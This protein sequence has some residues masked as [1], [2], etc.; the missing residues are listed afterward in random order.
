MEKKMAKK[1]K[2]NQNQ[3][4][5][6]MKIEETEGLTVGEVIDKSE[7]IKQDNANNENTLDKYI[8]QHRSQIE[9]AKSQGL[10]NF[11]KAEREK[12]A[13][14]PEE[15]KAAEKVEEK[16]PEK[17]EPEALDKVEVAE[18]KSGK[19]AAKIVGVAATEAVALDAVEVAADKKETEP[20]VKA[21]EPKAELEPKA[22]EPEPEKAVE[23][24]PAESPAPEKAENEE[25]PAE[26]KKSKKL[27]ILIGAA[28][29]VLI[30][31]GAFG[32]AQA[33]KP[34][35]NVN[36]TAT[37]Y[38]MADYAK[39][40]QA[41]FTD[42]QTTML[43]N[44]EFAKLPKLEKKI[45]KLPK[46]DQGAAKSEYNNLKRQIDATQEV[47]ALFDKP[48]L[49][50]GKLDSTAQVK[51]DAK[52]PSMQNTSNVTLNKLLSQAIDQAK[53]QQAKAKQ[54]ADAAAAQKAATA[55]SQA[56]AASSAAVASSQAA[57]ES[58]E[59]A[60]SSDT[61]ST[62]A[63]SSTTEQATGGASGAQN[64]SGA[65]PNNANARVQPQPGIN[66]SDPAF[67]WAPGVLDN[68][69]NTCRSR[70]YF[71][72]DNYILEPVAIHTT[73]AGVVSGYYNLYKSDGTYLVSI[74]CK[75]GYWFGTTKGLPLDY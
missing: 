2:N 35:H 39:D 21:A 36:Q 65:T 45:A 44:S 34:S 60:A 13:P 50:N 75:T 33:N 74:N 9:E 47:N 38:N 12:I 55:A 63:A 11:I 26:K 6:V 29:V 32:L 53:A 8:R 4:E 42:K 15:V 64:P 69:L 43:K 3:P 72:G 10:D 7:Q 30:G 23:P 52:I 49:V 62:A 28:A 5:K 17:T 57:A 48:A 37:S 41:F 22:V 71:T 40:Y 73:T 1:K 14:E 70:G 20:E 66:T 58:S 27:P 19:K 68:I 67:D 25:K 31:A 16:V 46:S 51:A 18:K 54:A 61:D 59:Q 24:V 56:A